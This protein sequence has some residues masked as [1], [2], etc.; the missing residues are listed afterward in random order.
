VDGHKTTTSRMRFLAEALFSLNMAFAAT[1]MLFG[2]SLSA[3]L[4]F[5]HL[6]VYLNHLLGIT[7]TDYIRGYFT[8]W[9]PSLVLAI[10]LLMLLRF[11]S[12]LRITRRI[13][14][15]VAGILILLSPTVVWTFG[16]ELH[17][18]WSLQWPYKVIWGEAV[19]AVICFC[20]FLRGPREVSLKL[21]LAGLFGH[22]TF[23]YWFAG[24][25]FRCP[26]SLYW[27]PVYGDLYGM[28]LGFS[29]MLVW[30]FYAYRTRENPPGIVS[31]GLSN[32]VADAS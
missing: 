22:Y 24:N 9:I 7:Q 1:S 25:G 19:F 30:S 27:G 18:R 12:G 3:S 29:A 23:W 31:A 14:Q 11:L 10:C 8:L 4:P 26:W 2:A 6:E 17:S 5:I 28:V 20:V 32:H 21:G 13:M 15:S 16:Y